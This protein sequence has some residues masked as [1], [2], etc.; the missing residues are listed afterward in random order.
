MS[1]VALWPEGSC[2]QPNP[3]PMGD[4]FPGRVDRRRAGLQGRA[5][6]LRTPSIYILC[7][8]TLWQA[9]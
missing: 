4:F 5:V 6:P 1:F 9:R 8:P 2:R 3:C 7:V